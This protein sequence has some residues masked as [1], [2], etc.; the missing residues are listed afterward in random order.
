MPGQL[1]AFQLS[2]L[3]WSDLHPY[4]AVH[5]LRLPGP[6][7][8]D[9]LREAITN[10]LQRA[11]LTTLALDR[12]AGTY[13]YLEG[14]GSVEIKSISGDAADVPGWTPE[15]ER[16]L[17]T[18]FLQDQPFCPFRFFVVAGQERFA[19]GLV[20]FHPIADAVCITLLLRSIAGAYGSD[21]HSPLATPL[22][23]YPAP[24]DN[25][26]RYRP[27]VLLR[28]VA[29]FPSAF[30]NSRR[31]C[32]PQSRDA[33][34]LTNKV[35]FLTLDRQ[36]LS[37]MIRTA[38]SLDVTLND[39]FL[40]Y[41][42]RGVS[43]VAPNRSAT[44]RRQNLALG[45]IVNTRKD[46]GEEES[47]AFGV[48]LGSFVVQHPFPAGT[49]LAHLARDLGRQTRVIKQKRLY[50][51]AALDLT[52]GRLIMSLFSE[53]RRKKLYHRYY[54]LWGGLTNMNLNAIWPQPE[55]ARPM[56]YFRAVSTGPIAPLV[57]SITTSGHTATVGFAYRTAALTA[58]EVERVKASFREPI[59]PLALP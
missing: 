54:P 4:N 55:G 32:R 22:E 49:T 29:A 41:L 33:G 18:P 3:Q 47:R 21:G 9:R 25:L 50:L 16:Q 19:L 43:W 52:F 28:K 1:N 30:L 57:A 56:E 14:P 36:T 46:Y 45:C 40:A 35:T 20:Y 34:D 12:A 7:D 10:T 58:P 42:I 38:K 2:M 23:R 24:R 48:F 8:L 17:N 6:L 27:G 59:G 11:G 53:R 15:I 31:R 51:G 13:W 37:G 44:D 39:L 26:L 5:V